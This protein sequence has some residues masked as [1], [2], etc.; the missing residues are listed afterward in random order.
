MPEAV[1]KLL[2]RL[3]DPE[4]TRVL[5]VTLPEATPVHEAAKLEVDLKRARI[6]P[7]AW[8]FRR[9]HNNSR[10]WWSSTG[11]SSGSARHSVSRLRR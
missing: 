4:F 9:G 8:V 6:S 3:R 1:E 2:P 11:Q 7:F 5:I 10:W